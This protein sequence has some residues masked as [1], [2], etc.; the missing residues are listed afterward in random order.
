MS[1]CKHM[2]NFVETPAKYMTNGGSSD[3]AE[4]VNAAIAAAA[5][6]DQ[7]PRRIED[8]NKDAQVWDKIMADHR[9]KVNAIVDSLW[10]GLLMLLV[11]WAGSILS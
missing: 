1:S 5:A 4:N 7:K 9:Q 3:F 6:A 2:F 11:W 8:I 10:G